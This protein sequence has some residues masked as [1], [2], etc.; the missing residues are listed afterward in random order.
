MKGEHKSAKSDSCTWVHSSV[1]RVGKRD[2][3]VL[4]CIASI[5][6]NQVLGEV[7]LAGK[8]KTVD[9][10][11]LQENPPRCAE[12]QGHPGIKRCHHDAKSMTKH[13]NPS[14]VVKVGDGG[15]GFIIEQRIR[16]AAFKPKG[17]RKFPLPRLVLTPAHCLPKLPPAHALPHEYER[18]Y[19]DL[20]SS[21][22]GA[23]RCAQSFDWQRAKR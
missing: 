17:L 18:S 14:S 1:R 8:T 22:D 15:R 12:S 5:A 2:S 6:Q 20:L 16:A 9:P 4:F 7:H 23:K 21:L 11:G 19:P 13:P 3:G 10:N